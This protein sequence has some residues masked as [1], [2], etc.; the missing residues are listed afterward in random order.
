MPISFAERLILPEDVLMSDVEGESVILNVN[1]ER[2][3][4]LDEVG[5][6]M[7]S[8]LTESNSVQTAYEALLEEYE[9]ENE[10]LRRD[11]ADLI[12]RL[13]GQGLLE[14]AREEPA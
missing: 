3:F 14:V 8:V 7:L 1:T 2:Y 6:R 12:D 5:T 10:T 4:G 11:L 9:V 13:L